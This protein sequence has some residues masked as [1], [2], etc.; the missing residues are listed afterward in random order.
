MV[1]VT[2]AS[3]SSDVH[4]QARAAITVTIA[5]SVATRAIP[6]VDAG[7]H[8]HVRAAAEVRSSTNHRSSTATALNDSIVTA[9]AA[10]LDRRTAAASAA[11]LN[12]RAAAASA[13]LD[14]WT[15]AASTSAA[16]A[17]STSAASATATVVTA[18]TATAVTTSTATATSSAL[19]A[20]AGIR[21]R[22]SALRQHDARIGPMGH[23][24]CRPGRNNLGRRQRWQCESQQARAGEI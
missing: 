5:P 20:T 1:P 4:A 23:T 2:P 17:A 14:G 15:A 7:T 3:A 13:A 9:S 16:S 22:P 21:G 11:T 6:D 19:A 10:T 18:S 12:R 24:G 8:A